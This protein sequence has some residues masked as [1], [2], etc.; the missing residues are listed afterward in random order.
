LS[1]TDIHIIAL[2]L[3]PYVSEIVH[4]KLCQWVMEIATMWFTF[5]PD[6]NFQIDLA[7]ALQVVALAKTHQPVARRY[8]ITHF[9]IPSHHQHTFDTI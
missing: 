2:L 8:L 9:P 6:R 1:F 7:R 3:T 5:S 4:F